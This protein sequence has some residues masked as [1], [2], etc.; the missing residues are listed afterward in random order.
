MKEIRHNG[1]TWEMKRN[2]KKCATVILWVC[3]WVLAVCFTGCG[4]PGE[5]ISI[6]VGALKGPTSI[7]I[8]CLMDKAAKGE[9]EDNYEF[10]MAVA[11]DELLSLMAKGELDIAL[12]PANVAAAF[13]Q[14]TEGG[15][16]V[17]DINTLGVLYIV[18]GTDEVDSVADLKGKTIYLTG[19][20]TTPEASLRYILAA[21]G[22][23]ESEY[24]LEFKTEATEVAAI[25]AE[26]PEAV[27]LLPQPFVTAALLQNDTLKVALD[28]NEE[29]RRTG[30]QSEGMITGVT[31]V[32]RAFLEEHPQAVE[33]FLK[34]H[35]LSA[36][37]VNADAEA[38]A[39][40]AVQAGIVAKESIAVKAIPQCHITCVTGMEMK[41]AL[42][43]YFGVLA[44]FNGQL[45]GGSLPNDD[46]YYLGNEN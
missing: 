39:V 23:K 10:R 13:Y 12:V 42:S 27:G 31:I 20:G 46:F 8:L 17:I 29:W 3:V 32:R 37:A 18:T 22:L 9:T 38:A 1:V 4:Q 15:V 36:T 44:E 7:G 35:S 14:K 41:G 2:S 33:T 45:V 16:A 43:A 5:S 25:L 24:T 21:N 26:N 34:E 28:M 11:A 40:L 6:R 19:K 30:N